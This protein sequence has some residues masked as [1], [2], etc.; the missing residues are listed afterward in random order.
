MIPVGELIWV[1]VQPLIR[2]YASPIP[3]TFLTWLIAFREIDFY[4]SQAALP[5]PKR[6]Y[7]PL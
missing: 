7:Y 3:C 1:S 6:G 4:V 2:L 5:S